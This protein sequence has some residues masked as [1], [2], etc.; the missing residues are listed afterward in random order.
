MKFAISRASASYGS[1]KQP[2]DGAVWV[3]D[4]RFS[5]YELKVTSLKQLMEIVEKEGSVILGDGPSILIYDDY[6]E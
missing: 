6:V 5:R 3:E 4:G 1:K 2:Y